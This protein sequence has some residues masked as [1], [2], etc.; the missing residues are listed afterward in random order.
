MKRAAALLCAIALRLSAQIMPVADPLIGPEPAEHF[1]ASAASSRDMTIVAWPGS[2][3][4]TLLRRLAPDGTPLDALP[5]SIPSI[6]SALIA[7]DGDRF[8]LAG[9]GSTGYN[10][11]PRAL[12][13]DRDG[14][15]TPIFLLSPFFVQPYMLAGGAASYAALLRNP[16]NNNVYFV[17][18]GRDGR[19][20]T[21]PILTALTAEPYVE[22]NAGLAVNDDGVALA[23]SARTLISIVN[24][25]RE[26]TAL[27][28]ISSDGGAFPSIASDGRGFLAI[29]IRR[30]SIVAQQLDQ[31]GTPQ[32]E[33]VTIPVPSLRSAPRVA[34]TGSQY[35]IAWVERVGAHWIL[36]NAAFNPSGMTPVQIAE[37]DAQKRLLAH[38][39]A[40]A[41]WSDDR[42]VPL[43]FR[44]P[45][46]SSQL[47]AAPTAAPDHEV[48]VSATLQVQEPG[49]VLWCGD[50][51]V[52]AW[53]E[54]GG[55]SRIRLSRFTTS[56]RL[57]PSGVG[58]PIFVPGESV[59]QLSPSL[60]C[61]IE[62]C[63]VAWLEVD[64]TKPTA[65]ARLALFPK[66]DLGARPKLMIMSTEADAIGGVTVAFD[67]EH[68]AVAWRNESTKIIEAKR[69]TSDGFH[70]DVVPIALTDT[71]PTANGDVGPKLSWNGREF[72]LVWQHVPSAAT[73]YATSVMAWR[74]TSELTPIFLP[75]EIDVTQTQYERFLLDDVSVTSAGNGWAIGINDAKNVNR[76]HELDGLGL[77]RR[78]TTLANYTYSLQRSGIAFGDGF[79]LFATQGS[80]VLLI[81]GASSIV[82]RAAEQYAWNVA[83]GGAMPV[84]FIASSNY[85]PH[86]AA[87]M[88]LRIVLKKRRAG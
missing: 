59:D 26:P 60:A 67:G 49:P 24:F 40:L 65:S 81:D 2:S 82:T 46:G 44:R 79:G 19:I 64:R 29:W 7:S 51:Y 5:L 15:T 74:F 16:S 17:R 58:L 38:V 57:E 39:G 68:Y 53:R 61:G 37:G 30:Q 62:Q 75:A 80:V 31:T 54:Y 83:I 66:N 85:H 13:L 14:T 69:A 9:T 32:G 34:W 3:D 52:A 35:R 18:I 1:F 63:A 12:L 36:Q 42:F 56:N 88:P 71:G 21:G 11:A 78:T 25:G 8:L 87:I 28:P 47:F 72:L 41:I 43:D 27:S 10:F 22:Y 70:V 6:S 45:S 86:N 33:E 23:V 84:A 73:Q 20:L 76:A 55:P 77:P 48:L 4:S 50:S